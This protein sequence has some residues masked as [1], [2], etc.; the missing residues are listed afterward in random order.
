LEVGAQLV[1]NDELTGRQ[2]AEL[3]NWQ[4]TGSVGILIRAKLDFIQLRSIAERFREAL[5][6]RARDFN[7]SSLLLGR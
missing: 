3:L 6:Q 5:Q 4:V 7:Q 2:V 1:L